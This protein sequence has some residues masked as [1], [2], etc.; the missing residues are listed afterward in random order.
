[1]PCQS[2]NSKWKISRSHRV[3]K[4]GDK[5]TDRNVS[6]LGSRRSYR[7]SDYLKEVIATKL[8]SLHQ[9]ENF[10][11]RRNTFKPKLTTTPS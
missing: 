5:G 7:E 10:P 11:I 6:S 1:M 2:I 4:K 3:K 8:I 9:G